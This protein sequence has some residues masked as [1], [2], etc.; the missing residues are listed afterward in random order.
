MFSSAPRRAV[1]SAEMVVSSVTLPSP[2][3][4]RAS[5]VTASSIPKRSA[6]CNARDRPGTPHNNLYVGASAASSNSTAAFSNTPPGCS[7]F[8]ALSSPWCVVASV[9]PAA[10][11]ASAPGPT[12]ARRS[13]SA[14]PIALPSAG[15]VPV[16]TSSMSTSAPGVAASRIARCFARRALNVESDSIRSCASPMSTRTSSNQ[17]KS[18]VSAGTN[19][20]ARAISADN[21]TAFIAAVLPPVFG[22]VITTER[23]E[24]G[25]K[26]STGTGPRTTGPGAEEEASPNPESDPR[27]ERGPSNKSSSA[28]RASSPPAVRFA[29]AALAAARLR[30]FRARIA[31]AASTGW[32]R[33][34]NSTRSSFCPSPGRFSSSPANDSSSASGS[35]PSAPPRSS[36]GNDA[37]ISAFLARSAAFHAPSSPSPSPSSRAGYAPN[38]RSRLCP[39][40]ATNLGRHALRAAACL[41]LAATTSRRTTVSSAAKRSVAASATSYVSFLRIA[42]IAVSS[43]AIVCAS[44]PFSTTT[45]GGS[46]RTSAPPAATPTTSDPG[47][48]GRGHREH[49]PPLVRRHRPVPALQRARLSFASAAERC[50]RAR[51]SS[52]DA[53]S[54]NP[55]GRPRTRGSCPP[56]PGAA[57]RRRRRIAEARAP[58]GRAVLAHALDRLHEPG[59]TGD[60]RRHRRELVAAEA[61]VLLGFVQRPANL[62]AHDPAEVEAGAVKRLHRHGRLGLVE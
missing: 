57:R 37:A 14:A 16:P 33:P 25:T 45:L 3:A 39:G 21:P 12:P 27:D 47:G 41:P 30:A 50:D 2:S 35:A 52:G 20:P 54:L 9:S 10:L 59:G 58:R 13:S 26:T 34:A 32:R 62:R 46:T 4:R 23:A 18:A 53:L 1:S 7:Y 55:P 17:G 29:A 11:R 48:R 8:S 42:S 22:P 19:K 24:R 6:I 43:A 56:P 5:R 36:V 28:P 51:R 38:P 44:C 31:C 15:L 60:E 61:R 49:H 40:G